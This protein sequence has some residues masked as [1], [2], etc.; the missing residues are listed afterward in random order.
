MSG[1]A[2]GRRIRE[3]HV[4]IHVQGSGTRGGIS[5]N[6]WTAENEATDGSRGNVCVAPTRIGVSHF[7]PKS[8]DLRGA[9]LSKRRMKHQHVSPSKLKIQIRLVSKILDCVL[10]T[11][12]CRRNIWHS[13]PPPPCSSWTPTSCNK[14]VHMS[15]AVRGPHRLPRPTSNRS[16]P[17]WDQTISRTEALC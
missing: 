15:E 4:R 1:T 13:R 7:R 5:A 14:I 10:I 8:S 11:F 6:G 9:N 2:A 17:P 12:H 16:P 3:Q